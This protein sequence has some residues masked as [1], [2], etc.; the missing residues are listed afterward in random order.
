MKVDKEIIRILG[1]MEIEGNTCRIT[2]Q[3]SRDMY[4]KTAKVLKGM[5]GKWVSAK[6][7]TVFPEGTDIEGTVAEIAATGEFKSLQQEY[8]FFPTPEELAE[9]IVELAGIEEGDRCL[10][11][12]A[13]RGNI[14]KF[15]PGCDC[16]ELNP[17]N[18]EY[19]RQ[20]G[21][22]VIAADFMQFVPDEA[23]YDVI[24]MNPPFCKCQDAAH[25]IKAIKMAKKCVVAIMGNG[26]MF[27][28]DK[29]YKEFRELVEQYGG[30]LEALPEDSF[31]ES[32]TAV[33]TCLAVIRK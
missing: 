11:P 14:A 15:M 9:K 8:Q 29:I 22:N 5:G 17:E 20:N 26:A 25:V 12:S 2:E 13:G 1:D 30:T 32:G 31:K 23:A 3:L 19:L 33:N 24:V 4:S 10:E 16:I 6:K 7:C 21:F 28:Q 27:R 18:A